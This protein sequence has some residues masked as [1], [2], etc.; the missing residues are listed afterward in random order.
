MPRTSAPGWPELLATL[1]PAVSVAPNRRAAYSRWPLGLAKETGL[2]YTPSARTMSRGVVPASALTSWA[3]VL[4]CSAP[5]G[6]VYAAG[7]SGASGAVGPGEGWSATRQSS[8]SVTSAS[9]NA[10]ARPSAISIAS[11]RARAFASTFDAPTLTPTTPTRA[12]PL[13][14][15]TNPALAGPVIPRRATPEFRRV[16]SAVEQTANPARPKLA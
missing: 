13:P 12:G 10:S 4:T 7:G 16:R 6:T 1:M 8:R 3:E 14:I 15:G 5:A 11:A 9:A 2:S